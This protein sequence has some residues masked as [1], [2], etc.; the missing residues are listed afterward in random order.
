M[1]HN[2]FV[3]AGGG[4]SYSVVSHCQELLV[5]DLQQLPLGRRRGVDVFHTHQTKT[6]VSPLF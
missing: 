2:N 5:S 6:I 1:S 3:S 4:N